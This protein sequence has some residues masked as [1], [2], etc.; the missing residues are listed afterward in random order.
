MRT[1]ISRRFAREFDLLR[2]PLLQLGGLPFSDVLSSQMTSDASTTIE[3]P[4][5]DRIFSLLGT[6]WVFLEQ[7]LNP[8]HSCRAAVARLIA[9]RVAHGMPAC[10][11]ETRADCQARKRLPLSFFAGVVRRV[12]QALDSHAKA[13]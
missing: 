12:G 5:N 2:R 11:S 10:S 13:E 3:T 6:L 1:S 4:W 9:Y 8:D 7:V